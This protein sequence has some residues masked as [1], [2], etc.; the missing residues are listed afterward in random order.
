MRKNIATSRRTGAIERVGIFLMARNAPGQSVSIKESMSEPQADK[1]P[2]KAS[3]ASSAETA[4]AA[5]LARL[6]QLCRKPVKPPKSMQPT[7]EAAKS[8]IRRLRRKRQLLIQGTRN[9]IS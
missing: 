1:K 5:L 4:R 8:K 3:S 6:D 2:E 9:K 7:P